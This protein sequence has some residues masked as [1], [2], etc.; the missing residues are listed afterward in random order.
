MFNIRARTAPKLDE[1]V[2]KGFASR[3][4][5]DTD[6]QNQLDATVVPQG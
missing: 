5:D 1:D 4:V 3:G 2:L 6:V